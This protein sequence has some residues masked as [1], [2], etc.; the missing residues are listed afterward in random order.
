MGGSTGVAR[1]RAGMCVVLAA[2]CLLVSTPASGA[3]IFGSPS[4]SAA[5][6][7]SSCGAAIGKPDGSAWL[8]TFDDEFDGSSL[9]T[10]KWVVQT[11]AASS[12]HS[13]AECFV[14]TPDNVAVAGGSLSLT[15]RREAAPF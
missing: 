10:S 5:T 15:V 8:C 2:A 12:F 13:G 4:S 9:D 7:T 14:N 11:T 1:V 6:T 3:S